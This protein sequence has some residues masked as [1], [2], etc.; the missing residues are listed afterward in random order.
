MLVYKKN[1]LRIKSHNSK[2]ISNES[3]NPSKNEA[4]YVME[5]NQFSDLTE[6]EFRQIYTKTYPTTEAVVEKSRLVIN[7]Y[8]SEV[9]QDCRNPD[10]TF[11]TAAITV[12]TTTDTVD[13]A[14]LDE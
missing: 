11:S 2:V 6:K 1:V 9:C 12:P 8:N 4:S 13:E 14:K 3:L 10:Q 7:A 5:I